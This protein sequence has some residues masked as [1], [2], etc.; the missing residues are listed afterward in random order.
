MANSSENAKQIGRN[1]TNLLIEKE[2]T[3]QELAD[4][5][6]VSKST[7]STWT[8]GKRIPRMDKVD[9][10]CKYFGVN[11]SDILSSHGFR[12]SD[13]RFPESKVAEEALKKKIIE[14]MEEQQRQQQQEYYDNEIVHIVTDRLRTNPEY[15]VLFKASADVKPEDIEFVTKFIEK[16]SD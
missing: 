5:I 15:G 11:R 4:A 16:M 8:N 13:M 1:I 10:M 3:Q 9:L 7:V 2:K 14:I 6:G 12:V